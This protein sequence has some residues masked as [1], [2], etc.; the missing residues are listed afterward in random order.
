[1]V[2]T[3]HVV[4]CRT[5]NYENTFGKPIENV[6]DNHSLRLKSGVIDHNDACIKLS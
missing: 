6:P 5:P 4:K 3:R 2:Y 1:M